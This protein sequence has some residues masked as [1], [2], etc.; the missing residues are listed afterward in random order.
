VAVVLC[1]ACGDVVSS[2]EACPTCGWPEPGAARHEASEVLD[3]ALLDRVNVALTAQ[4]AL[5][6]R[7]A[8]ERVAVACR[9][10]EESVALR[11]RLRRQRAL[12]RAR[13]ADRR[14]LVPQMRETL[15]RVEG[16][17]DRAPVGAVRRWRM[18]AQ[19]PRDDSCPAVARRL[20]E[21][22]VHE[23]FSD[24]ER[25]GAMLIVSELVTNA[26]VHGQGTILLSL[27]RTDDVL[28]IEVSDEGQPDHIDVLPVKQRGD[29]GRGLW[30]VEQLA[31]DWGA[32]AGT[33]QVWAEVAIAG[34]PSGGR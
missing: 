3:E 14:E 12:L 20:L 6:Q 7:T 27:C 26:L 5:A 34:A 29:R 30:I 10:Y 25:E 2:T 33:G 32:E 16:A 17:L 8:T 11:R 28:R 24:E 15:R 23:D 19:L 1:A 13:V 18:S 22:H 4:T 21:E 31:T 9:R